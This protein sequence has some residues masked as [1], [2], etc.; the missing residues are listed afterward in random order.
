MPLHRLA[1]IALLS[2]SAPGH[3]QTAVPQAGEAPAQSEAPSRAT[4]AL[5]EALRLDELLAVM[6]EEGLAQAGTLQADMFPSGGGTEWVRALDG[7]YDVS[8]LR[9]GFAAAIEAELGGNPE[10]LSEI[11]AFYATDLG[12][13][14]V[15]L[16]IEARRAFLDE[17][18]EDAARVAAD[19]RR[20]SRDPRAGQLER[21]IAA[22]DLVEMNVAGALSGNLAFMTGMNDSGAYGDGLPRDQL[23]QDVWGQED[24]IRAETRSWLEAYLGLAYQPL[25]DAE[26]D[27]Y[28]AFMESPAG[29]RLNGALFIAFDQV[30][31]RVSYELG[32][33]A[34][35]AMLGTDI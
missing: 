28:I 26:L 8:R 27:V 31:R 12:Q 30:F 15:L 4:E 9:K 35:V 21:F 22:G 16:E 6:R 23:M 10:I 5:L 3:A 13:R 32:R 19:K 1:L 20:A 25:D 18:A 14:V 2:L 17:A 24:Q 34:G 7:I 29:R 11:L 33:A